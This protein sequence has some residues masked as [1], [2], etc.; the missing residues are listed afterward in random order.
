[1]EI[2]QVGFVLLVILLERSFRLLEFRWPQWA[3]VSPGYVIG[4]LGA[5]WTIQ[6]LLILNQ[7][8]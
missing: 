2:G 4:A 1:V 5:Y 6:R 7:T 3:A 8:F